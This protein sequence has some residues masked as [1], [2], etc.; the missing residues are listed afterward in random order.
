M[1]R[2]KWILAAALIL[3]GCTAQ[4]LIP[5]PE[6]PD[7]EDTQENDSQEEQSEEITMEQYWENGTYYTVADEKAVKS[8]YHYSVAGEDVSRERLDPHLVFVK[9]VKEDSGYTCFTIRDTLKNEDIV[10]RIRTLLPDTV[11]QITGWM[12]GSDARISIDL[13][14]ANE[15]L[16]YPVKAE[17]SRYGVYWMNKNYAVTDGFSLITYT[18]LPEGQEGVI[19]GGMVT[20]RMNGFVLV[21]TG[22]L[23]GNY[24][25]VI[26]GNN[27]DVREDERAELRVLAEGL[28]LAV[29]QNK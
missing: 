16:T 17:N 23:N 14:I 2:N 24:D 22:I 29:L 25:T 3:T 13:K 6:E 4:S 26:N 15:I 8:L 27:K 12:E 9:A 19:K 5:V 21:T 10:F 20:D 18:I 11:P 7:R 1:C 28:P